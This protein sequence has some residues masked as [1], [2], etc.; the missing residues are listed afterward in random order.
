MI[1]LLKDFSKNILDIQS[2]DITTE[3]ILES[4]AELLEMI[5]NLKVCKESNEIQV[6]TMNKQIVEL[7]SI[8]DSLK[9]DYGVLKDQNDVLKEEK[10]GYSNTN[11]ENAI[12]I[13]EL[14]ITKDNELNLRVLYEEL[15]HEQEKLNKQ[16]EN[17]TNSIKDKDNNIESLNKT[18]NEYNE[19][20]K[21]SDHMCDTKDKELTKFKSEF[22]TLK[23]KNE[24]YAV[25]V[26]NM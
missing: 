6:D 26:K 8:I 19:L 13:K 17:L 10:N 9:I 20:I 16:I 12:K 2:L 18:L 1:K 22:E 25:E 4:L 24:E 7:N 11:K 15:Q 21:K 23:N 5:K 14:K 3:N